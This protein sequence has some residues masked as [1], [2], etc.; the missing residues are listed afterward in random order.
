M[1]TAPV[2]PKYCR[3]DVLAEG[4]AMAIVNKKTRKALRKGVKKVIKKHGPKLAA[5]LAGG[6]AST[7]ATL[8]STEAPGTKGKQSNLGKLSKEV[9]DMVGQGD[10]KSRKRD[11]SGK[12]KQKKLRKEQMKE[13]PV[14]RL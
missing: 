7:L 5:G 3:T 4:A 2:S 8:A 10:K 6:V 12:R 11:G 9:T 14:E 13:E 1:Q